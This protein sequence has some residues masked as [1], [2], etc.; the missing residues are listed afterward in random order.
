MKYILL[1][2]SSAETWNALSPEDREQFATDHDDL[3]AELLGSGEWVGGNAL[4]DLARGR[5][6]RVRDGATITTEGPFAETREHLAGYTLLD[7]PSLDRAI[8][9]AARIPDARLCGV[10]VRE[11]MDPGGLEM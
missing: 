1:I 9:I 6:V 4:T 8:E 10:E 3:N 7:V 11:L 5:T 2:Y